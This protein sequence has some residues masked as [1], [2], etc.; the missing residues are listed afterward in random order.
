MPDPRE[1]VHEACKA[2]EIGDA[3]RMLELFDPDGHVTNPLAAGMSMQ[4]FRGLVESFLG[5]IS[6]LRIE[7]LAAI[8]EGH[9][10]AA[11][12]RMTGRHTGP[13]SMPSGEL[14]ASGRAIELE[15]GAF[16]TVDDGRIAHWRAYY[17]VL[18]LM[19]QFGATPQAATA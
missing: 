17:D 11:R 3:D 16:V 13:L 15:E 8:A 18:E 19:R 10:V 1:L 9:T 6:D 12:I 4:E 2:M 14:P 7:V 5:A